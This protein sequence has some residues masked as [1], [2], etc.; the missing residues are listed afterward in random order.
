MAGITMDML[1]EDA[2]WP[3]P[4]ARAVFQKQGDKL[5]VIKSI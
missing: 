1:N 3:W 2:V 5:V 4:N